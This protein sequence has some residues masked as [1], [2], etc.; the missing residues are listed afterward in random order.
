M[1]YARAANLL[2]DFARRVLLVSAENSRCGGA[3]PIKA[4][5]IAIGVGEP[6]FL[7]EWEHHSWRVRVA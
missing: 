5:D 6:C 3:Q 4:L 7:L 1:L 2:D